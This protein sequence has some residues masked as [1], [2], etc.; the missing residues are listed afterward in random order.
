MKSPAALENKNFL[1]AVIA[2]IS[3][4]C[5]WFFLTWRYGFDLADEGYYWYGAQRVLGGEVPLRDFLSY[6]IGR[7]YWAAFLM[8]LMG[9]DGVLGARVSA[10]AFQ[11]LGTI[12]GVY[13]CLLTLRQGGAVRWLFA[14]FFACILTIWVWP[15]YKS[16]DQAISIMVVAFL[17]L[18]LKVPKRSAWLGA[19]ICL[20]VAAM[21]GRNHGVYGAAAATFIIIM[22]LLVAQTPSRRL[23]AGL[24]GFF[25][26]GVLI[27][28]SPTLFMMLAVDGF[29]S[30]FIDSVTMLIR[31]GTT[32]ITLSVPWPWAWSLSKNLVDSGS[33]L[34]AIRLS[35]SVGFVF[36][37][38]F[39]VIGLLSLAY[40]R[41]NLSDDR[42]K[43]L[44]ATIAAS[45]PYAHYALSRADAM[46]LSGGIFP[47]LIGVMVASGTMYK[48]RTLIVCL[49]L[50]SVSLLA[51]G[52]TQPFLSAHLLRK[53]VLQA[54]IDGKTLWLYP[55][56]FKRLQWAKNALVNQERSEC[57]FLALPDMTSLYA[58]Y[59]VKMPIW[60]IYPLSLKDA[61]FQNREI[62][63]LE[64]CLPQL[65]L[66]SDHALDTNSDFRYSHMYPLIYDWIISKYETRSVGDSVTDSDLKVYFLKK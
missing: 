25:L 21:V 30:A 64:S 14:V 32:N 49:I 62:R 3:V 65:V 43:I 8:Y 5:F 53:P 44:L 48:L 42:S 39:P 36:L 7:Y 17:V 13:F 31:G 26:L 66:L 11:A 6:D 34:T 37:I 52:N 47:A 16:Y 41:F 58:I 63:R 33:L 61:E 45:I 12:L 54:D 20:G 57:S 56:S 46:H 15:Y 24:S 4:T 59:R 55:G 29:S 2:A 50:F 22:L 9:D 18:M 19:G 35:F 51:V 60:E 23:I 27:G 10:V 38:T 40:S 1:V 28:F